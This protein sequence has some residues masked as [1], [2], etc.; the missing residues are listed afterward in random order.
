MIA[1]I[2]SIAAW[3]L[4]ARDILPLWTAISISIITALILVDKLIWIIS[5]DVDYFFIRRR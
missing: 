3:G 1:L 2:L 5:P 4:F